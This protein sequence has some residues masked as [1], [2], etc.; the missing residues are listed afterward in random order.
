MICDTRFYVYTQQL[1]LLQGDQLLE[2]VSTQRSK[3][4]RELKKMKSEELKV[5]QN[6]LAMV[7]GCMRDPVH[8]CV[9]A[10]VHACM[11]ACV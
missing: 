8:V 3:E 4:E 1:R 11:H 10:C 7:S 5:A 2:K 6:Q 9:G